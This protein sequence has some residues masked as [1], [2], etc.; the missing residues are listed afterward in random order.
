MRTQSPPVLWE[1]PAALLDS[2]TM[3]RFMRQLEHEQ[4]LAFASYDE[5]WHWSVSDIEAFWWAIWRVFG[6]Q[7]DGDPEPVLAERSMPG[8]RWFPGVR[9]SYAEHVLRG[10]AGDDVAIVHA[11]EVRELGELTSGELRE[12]VKRI[13]AGLRRLGVSRGDRV[14]ALIP[15]IA[16]AVAAFLATASLGAVWSSCSPDFG[17]TSVVDRFS[18]IEQ[19][20][21]LA[22]DGYHYGGR[23]FPKSEVIARLQRELPTLERTVVLPYLATC[24][25]S[26]RWDPPGRRS[27]PRASGGS[28][29]SSARTLGCSRCRAGLMSARRSSAARR[30]SRYGPA[31][32][33]R[34]PS[35]RTCTRSVPAA[36][37]SWT[38]SASLS[39]SSRCRR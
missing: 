18:Q 25:A 37:I 30:S 28:T 5:L 7:A 21:L 39:S 36:R 6:V 14:V 1:P 29:T 16:E 32:S 3:T 23:D 24:P 2:S 9:L 11:G 26:R 12:Q 20:V 13:R 15:N 4:G 22:V 35:A 17:V 10:T 38:R 31:S 27:R 8:T 19:K 34:A 33:R